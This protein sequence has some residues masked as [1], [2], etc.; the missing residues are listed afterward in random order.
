MND[1]DIAGKVMQRVTS[2]I[3]TF[4]PHP[5]SFGLSEEDI[6]DITMIVKT[7]VLEDLLVFAMR[8]PAA[9]KMPEYILE[10]YSSFSAVLHYRVAH[11]IIDYGF[12]AY[13]DLFNDTA[14]TTDEE[15]AALNK[16]D[17]DVAILKV[18]R[19]ISERAKAETGVEIHPCASIGQRFV[20]DHGAGTVIG[21]TAEI[22]D[23]CYFLQAVVLG[24]PK[25]ADGVSMKRHPTIGNNVMV[26]GGAHFFGP[27]RIGDRVVV[28]AGA[29]LSTSVPDD[30]VVK[31]LCALQICKPPNSVSIY[32][33]VPEEDSRFT[34]YGSGMVDLCPYLCVVSDVNGTNCYQ[35]LPD[36]S[37]EVVSQDTAHLSFRVRGDLEISKRAPV[38]LALEGNGVVGP[39]YLHGVQ[40]LRRRG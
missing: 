33:V 12:S 10:A 5:V 11:T 27:I 8:D 36:I 2:L 28:E 21:E 38:V 20:I 9:H 34:V 37:L 39:I 26:A 23:D 40:A 18:A 29:R 13:D 7:N 4:I 15:D 3:D 17:E 1:Q 24:G 22:G 16:Y 35:R 6:D 19:K 14:P 30:S 25:I 31:V 32:G